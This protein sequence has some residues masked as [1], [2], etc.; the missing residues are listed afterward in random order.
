MPL[1]ADLMLLINARLPKP[2]GLAGLEI[3][4]LRALGNDVEAWLT[5][6]AQPQPFFDDIQNTKNRRGTGSP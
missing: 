1:T 2:H 6:L 5:I 4:E 3:E